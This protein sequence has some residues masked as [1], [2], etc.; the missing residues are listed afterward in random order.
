MDGWVKKAMAFGCK[1]KK[2]KILLR[3]PVL[4]VATRGRCRP[5]S[6]TVFHWPFQVLPHC[7]KGRRQVGETEG[8][9]QVLI[10]LL[11]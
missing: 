8:V 1:F 11:L 9:G 2:K 6:N 10:W 7:L 4:Q 5:D 3:A